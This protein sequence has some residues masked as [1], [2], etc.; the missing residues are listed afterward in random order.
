M[1]GSTESLIRVIPDLPDVTV[2]HHE[3]LPSG[4][5]AYRGCGT[6]RKVDIERCR[7]QRFM[8]HQGLDRQEIDPVFIRWVPKA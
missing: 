3:H 1:I 4:H 6:D 5:A 2:S 8:T 7:F